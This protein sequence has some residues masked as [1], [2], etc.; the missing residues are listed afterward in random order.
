MTEALDDVP[1]RFDEWRPLQLAAALGDRDEVLRLLSK[2]ANPQALSS[3]RIKPCHAALHV[4]ARYGHAEICRILCQV[5]DPNQ[6]DSLGFSALHYAAIGNHLRTTTT[7]LRAGAVDF[8][9]NAR[10]SA[11]AVARSK[12]FSRVAEVLEEEQKRQRGESRLGEWLA[13]I[14]CEK[15]LH[16]IVRAG[17]DYDLIAE[18]GL[19]EEDIEA[20][21]IPRD[22]KGHQKKLITKHK[23][24]SSSSPTSQEEESDEDDDVEEEEEEVSSDESE[25]SSSEEE[26]DE[27]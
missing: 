24:P 14:G 23:F 6:L 10:T 18:H 19:T 26:S 12:G 4:A 8:P 25:S 27:G 17:Y 20:I 16:Q 21:G 7:L 11:A 1:F 5:A 15:Y 9:S 13:S 3:S 22:K 2:G